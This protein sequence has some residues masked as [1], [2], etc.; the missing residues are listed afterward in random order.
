M[1]RI[2][3]CMSPRSDCALPA[4]LPSSTISWSRTSSL[5]HCQT[6]GLGFD[7]LINDEGMAM[8]NP[9]TKVSICLPKPHNHRLYYGTSWTMEGINIAGSYTY[10]TSPAANHLQITHLP[11]ILIVMEDRGWVRPHGSLGVQV[12]GTR[13]DHAGSGFLI[14][15]LA[16]KMVQ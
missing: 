15:G 1:N 9:V 8:I 14:E 16:L 2:E 5:H 3:A 11:G 10:F 12:A 6:L 4:L 7:Y 13:D